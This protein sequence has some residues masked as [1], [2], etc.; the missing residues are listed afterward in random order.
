MGTDVLAQLI[1]TKVELLSQLRQLAARQVELVE[2]GDMTR[3]MNLLA[4]K[5]RLLNAVDQIERQLDPFRTE[6]A[7]QRAWQSP[8]HRQRARDASARCDALLQEIMTVERSCEAQL[9][10]RRD[11]AAEQLQ[12]MH[13]SAQVASAYL[14]AHDSSG[15]QFDA[16]CE[17]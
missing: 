14:A 6:D 8:A 3:I 12:G 11:Q 2:A 15:R 16:S 4:V 10:Q 9:F 17:T 7:E 13:F 5:Q 1:D